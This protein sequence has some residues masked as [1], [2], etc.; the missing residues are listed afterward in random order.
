MTKIQELAERAKEMANRN[1]K[2]EILCG[3]IDELAGIAEALDATWHDHESVPEEVIHKGEGQ[4]YSDDVL[5]DMNG[6]R[7][8]FTIGW[9]DHDDKEWKFY[10]EDTSMLEPKHLHWQKLPLKKYD[11]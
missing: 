4:G 7:K 3:I 8:N 5:I 2:P 1:V 9:F 6:N 11:V 10:W